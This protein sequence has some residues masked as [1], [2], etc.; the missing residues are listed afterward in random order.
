MKSEKTASVKK[1]KPIKL[2]A[3]FAHLLGNGDTL[4]V[5]VDNDFWTEGISNLPP[6]RLVSLL[7]SATDWMSWEKHPKGDEF[8][9]VLTGRLTL[10]FE[11]EGKRWSEDVQA[12][13]FVIV[14][15]GVWHTADAPE[16]GQALF[17]TAGDSTEH[18]E[19]LPDR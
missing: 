3:A 11:E 7:E 18:R 15:K 8:I 17:I 12:G 6:G 5:L 16:P 13:Q 10:I 9:L 4:S 2:G 1:T 19:R 14:P